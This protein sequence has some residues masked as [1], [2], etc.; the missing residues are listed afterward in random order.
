MWSHN[1][2]IKGS[3]FMIYVGIDVAK[4]NHD[5]FIVSSEGEIIKD[6]FT[7]KNNLDG[8][9]SLLAAILHQTNKY[10]FYYKAMLNV[11]VDK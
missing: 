2:F 6:I 9:D 3:D 11:N 7:F 10:L 5:C 1:Q 4:D 8:F